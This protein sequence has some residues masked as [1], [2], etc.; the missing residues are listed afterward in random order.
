M[1]PLS[2]HQL[3]VFW[4]QLTVIVAVARGLGGL[5]R[6]FGQ[7]SVVGE[8]SAGLLIGPSLLG[9]VA[10]DV[11]GWLF[12]ADPVQTGLLLSV[13]WIGV[14]LL[15]VVTGFET[16]LRLLAN[17]GR[18][19]LLSSTG[20]LLLPLAVGLGIGLALPAEFL[21]TPDSRLVFA[22][23]IAVALAVSALPVVAKVLMDMGLMRRNIGQI[24]VA[25]G[26]ANDLVG[27]LLL[28]TLA[29]VVTSGG[30]DW[31]SLGVTVAAMVA[32]IVGMLTVGQRFVDTMLRRA[33]QTEAPTRAA[34]T[35][36]LLVTV[37]AGALTQGIGV[38]AV[39]GTFVIGVVLGRSR[40][41][42][43]EVTSAIE[44][45]T[46]SFFAPVFF[47]TAGLFVDLGVLADPLVLSWTLALIAVAT[48]SK[49]VGAYAGGVAGGM[50]RMESL[51]V[52][53]GL[54]ARGAVGVVI[55]TV[56][57]SLEILSTASYTAVVVVSIATSMMAPPL[58]RPVLR[59]LR[60]S[61]AE[62]Q[63]L[64][65][66]SVLDAS[67]IA[68]TRSALLP[69]RGGTNSVLA[70]RLL[71]QAL[72]PD[73]SVTVFTVHP[74][75]DTDAKQRGAITARQ[76]RATLA[77]RRTDHVDK[78][79]ADSARA[80]CEEA[81]LGYGLVALGMTE[82]FSGAHSV[83][84]VLRN[85]LANCTTPMLLV[86]HGRDALEAQEPAIRKIMVPAAGTRLG[87][88]A[89]EIAF[90]LAQRTGAV[91]DLVHV[92]DRPD[93]SA[94][95]FPR[96]LARTESPA[97]TAGAAT[98]ATGV[99]ATGQAL[100]GRYG[101]DAGTVTRGGTSVGKELTAA[102]A[103]D[104]ADLVVLGA[105]VRVSDGSPFLG[106]HVEYVLEHAAALV[107]VVVF[108]E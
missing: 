67:V 45:M 95:R 52:G 65:R 90:T 2:E 7:P 12:P 104:R 66:E 27:W 98:S 94:P 42:T 87:Q 60:A 31:V 70:A 64:E 4:T 37:A 63:R 33:R 68:R 29:G 49:L 14:A 48:L 74:E 91:L 78:A 55:A 23:F 56:G 107:L 89:Q 62:A 6:R 41:Q 38:E 17:L 108:P 46:N 16:D 20:S 72:Q 54:N 61:P 47:A 59:R 5:L 101:L 1:T 43:Q 92:L 18:P 102:A 99:L 9:R 77:A 106:H 22:L 10:P 11:Y 39:L 3:L 105:R 15:M 24:T 13:A 81:D 34:L 79:S 100:A 19:A 85:V 76:V 103:Q 51:A 73:T 93:Q 58:L 57:L 80:I 82:A 75:G 35:A 71:D 26:M 69:T 97:D 28:G 30:F 53:I 36:A 50:S 25:G 40:Y 84:P 32:F 44:T 21:G 83:S 86:R 96:W 8:L 88:A